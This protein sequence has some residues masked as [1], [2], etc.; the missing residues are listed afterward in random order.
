MTIE[1]RQRS[2]IGD[3][4]RTPLGVFGKGAAPPVTEYDWTVSVMDRFTTALDEF[5][6]ENCQQQSTFSSGY[7]TLLQA[8]SNPDWIPASVGLGTITFTGATSGAVFVWNG[9][10]QCLKIP[11]FRDVIRHVGLPGFQPSN[12][13]FYDNIV[14]QNYLTLL[15][16]RNGPGE[17]PSFTEGEDL[18][19]TT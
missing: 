6:D 17:V 9:P 4:F 14:G 7:E 18:I 15:L 1:V 11:G 13:F 3:F 10:P 12:V 16:S 8:K 5:F 19:V 2:P